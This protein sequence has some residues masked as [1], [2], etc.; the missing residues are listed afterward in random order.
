MGAEEMEEYP[1]MTTSTMEEE[2]REG[3][4]C[5][6]QSELIQLEIEVGR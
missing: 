6:T 3:I 5:S 2:I 1:K 4:V